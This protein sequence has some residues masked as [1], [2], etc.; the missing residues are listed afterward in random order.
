MKT[1]LYPLDRRTFVKRAALAALAT[2]TLTAAPVLGADAGNSGANPLRVA[3]VTGG[4]TYDVLNFHRLFR[5][6]AGVDAYIQH[7]EDFVATPEPVRDQYDVVLCY[8]MLMQGPPDGP[9]KAALEHLGV[10]AQGIVV[11]H[12]ALLAYP[13]WPTWSELVGIGDRRFGF[14]Y[15]QR[16]QV[17]VARSPHPII[18]GLQSW[19]MTDETYTMADAGAGSEVLLTVDHPNSMK[20]IGWTRQF[21]QSRVFCLESG[22]DNQAWSNAH[23]REILKRG[24]H[25][26]AR[27]I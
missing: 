19:E 15:N 7:M 24:I 14:H 10:T 23:F 1:R 11:M 13:A 6:L 18:Q 2:P 20:T 25:W 27:R 5:A 26:S 3:V 16:I 12:H 17:Q 21:K 22:H 9:V 8:H 4:H